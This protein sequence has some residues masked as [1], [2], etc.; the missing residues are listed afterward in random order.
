MVSL[1][2]E[3]LPKYTESSISERNS[4]CSDLN[5][6]HARTRELRLT[7]VNL[8]TAMARD[9]LCY[10]PRRW[11][12]MLYH[13]AVL[14][15]YRPSLML[16]DISQNPVTAEYILVCKAVNHI[17][18]LSPS[19]KENQPQLVNSSI[20]HYM[21]TRWAGISDGSVVLPQVNKQDCL[22]KIQPQS[23]LSTTQE[24]ALMFLSLYPSIRIIS[25]IAMKSLIDL[26]T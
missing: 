26:V 3:S 12:E 4:L 7:D 5:G 24:L 17:V 10:R 8:S 13:N 2:G 21:S 18:L 23:K 14:I 19:A 6:W 9:R 1:R 25:G 15:L 16:P 22:I 11:F 20:R